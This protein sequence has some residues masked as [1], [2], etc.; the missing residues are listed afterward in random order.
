MKNQKGFSLI[1]L[2]IVVVIIGIIAA[3]AIPNLL[4]AR[5]S[6]NEGSAQA[7]VR[8]VHGAQMTYQSTTGS[9]NYGT[10][11]QLGTENLVDAQLGAASPQKSG[12]NFNSFD[13]D[14]TTTVAASFTLSAS[15]VVAAGL[16]Q[17]GSKDYCIA[18]EGIIRT[19]AAS[20]LVGSDGGCTAAAYATATGN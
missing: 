9:G 2:L 5:R 14:R 1:E 6:A 8:T 15:P 13:T 3:I 11:T 16:T 4:A 7:S 18:T 10:M 20:G 17:T 12:Y 19:R